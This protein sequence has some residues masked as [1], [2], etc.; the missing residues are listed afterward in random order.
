MK[1]LKLDDITWTIEALPED[2]S[3]R[4]NV[5]ASGDEDVD[6]QLENE[7]L[8]DINSGNE[9]AWC[10]VKV[11][12]EWNNLKGVDYMGSCSYKSKQDFIENSGYYDDMRKAVLEEIQGKLELFAKH[13]REA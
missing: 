6:R 12:G 8:E 7:V 3:V 10:I 4:G 13:V 1:Q 5:C 2:S 11:S 9:W